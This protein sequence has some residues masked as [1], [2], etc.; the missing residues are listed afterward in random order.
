MRH[1]R[2]TGRIVIGH[3]GDGQPNRW[4]VDEGAHAMRRDAAD[5]YSGSVYDTCMKGSPSKTSLRG[6]VN[7]PLCPLDAIFQ[8]PSGGSGCV[9]HITDV[10]VDMKGRGLYKKCIITTDT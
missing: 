6:I 5:P 8:P 7:G 3:V 9:I 4:T 2:F 10:I 1:V